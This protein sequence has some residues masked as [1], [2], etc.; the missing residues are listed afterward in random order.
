MSSRS[1]TRTRGNT[2]QV[3]MSMKMKRMKKTVR[4]LGFKFSNFGVYVFRLLFLVLLNS[5]SGLI[6]GLGFQKC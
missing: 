6:G 2:L 3:A 5:F 1:K 4:P